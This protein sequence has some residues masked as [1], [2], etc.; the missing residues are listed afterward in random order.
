MK[1]H[2]F[3]KRRVLLCMGALFIGIFVLMFSCKD[4]T[5]V[6]RQN[7]NSGEPHNPSQPVEV[8]GFIPEEGK[9]REKVIISGKNF[10]NDPAKV[11]VFFDDGYSEKTAQV[12]NVD[13]N[14]IYCLAP[15][16]NDGRSRIKVSV[17]EGQ[18]VAAE[19]QFLYYAAANVSWVAG[20]GKDGS[21]KRYL[22]GALSEA[23]FYKL[24]GIVALGNGQVMTVGNDEAD[25][26]HTRL[27]SEPDDKVITVQNGLYLGKQ[28]INQARTKVYAA[29]Q[30]PPHT[31][32]EYKKEA[33]WTPYA[34]GE[35]KIP[36]FTAD[37]HNIRSLA[38]MDEAHDPNQEW[39]YFHHRKKTFGRFNINTEETQLLAD[40]NLD[41]PETSVGSYM[42][43]DKTK[44]CFYVSLADRYS[45]YKIS[46]VG[47]DWKDGVKAE[48]FAGSPS[49]SAVTDGD[50]GDARFRQPQGMCMDDDG[51]LYICD[52]NNAYVIRKISGRDGYVST[53]AGTVNKTEP[54]VVNCDPGE[55]VLFYPMDISY[56]GDGNFYICE[57]YEASIIKYSIE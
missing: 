41:L 49:Q 55:A 27:V 32:Y 44:D 12:M 57:W 6:Y 33:G 19:R 42:V 39:V 22:D 40:N 43:Y 18:P 28:A 45:I 16:L 29:A 15:R 5:Y 25:G 13:G 17:E 46:K 34:V 53:I 2:R 54:Q 24:Q 56:D 7:Q 21:G 35:I 1:K 30:N 51:N 20:V 50:L 11:K 38:M 10:G 3:E 31:V 26:M 37:K 9:I 4:E 48:T 8:T 14:S 36:K 52:R 47:A 23:Y